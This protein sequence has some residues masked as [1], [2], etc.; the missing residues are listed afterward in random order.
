MNVLAEILSSRIRAE[1]FR[2]LFG[3]SNG[4]LHMREIERRSG[5]SIGTI[6]QE[7]KKLLRLELVRKKKD[8]NRLYYEANKEHPLYPDICNLVLKTI[9]LT[10]VF[11]KALRSN[12]AIKLAFV[13]GSVARHEEKGES[14]V[15][16]I[17][18]GEIGLRQLSGLLSGVS[19]Q[20]G[21]E[22]NPHVFSMKEFSR[23]KRVKEPFLTRVLESPKIFIIG[24]E[25]ELKAVA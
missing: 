9:G 4:S 3:I 16:L 12:P 19:T 8:G 22:I 14:D 11:R 23:R 10:E 15:D 25:D 1:I 5:L 24:N 17:V 7:L 20:I 6:Q 21:R 18:I 2:L 13:F